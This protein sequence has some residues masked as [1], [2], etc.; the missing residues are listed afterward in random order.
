M[1]DVPQMAIGTNSLGGTGANVAFSTPTQGNII[2]GNFRLTFGGSTTRNIPYNALDVDVKDALEALAPVE[3]VN[4]VRTGPDN[5]RGYVWTVTFTS[6]VNS[7]DLDPMTTVYADTLTGTG[8]QAQVATP[9]EGNQI[10]GTFGINDGSGS[11]PQ[12]LKFDASAGDMKAALEQLTDVGVVAV[13]RTGPDPELGY[14]WVVSFLQDEGNQPAL[15]AVQTLLTT[16]GT[17][18]T[19]QLVTIAESRAGTVKEVQ[20]ITTSTTNNEVQA[21]TQFRLE[22]DGQQTGLINAA[23]SCD[24]TVRE[25]QRITITTTNTYGRAFLLFT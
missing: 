21:D 4:V 13:T 6:D 5:Q 10:A 3:T 19:N 17:G 25:K 22:Y 14:Q 15:N 9:V 12:T 20:T 18:A 24:T 23:G 16:T 1:G 7:G 11:G 2:R 8:A